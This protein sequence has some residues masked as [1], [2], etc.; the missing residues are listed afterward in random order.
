MKQKAAPP[1]PLRGKRGLP[2]LAAVRIAIALLLLLASC[3]E[4]PAGPAPISGTIETDVVRIA[5]RHGGRIDQILS[6]EGDEVTNN[7]PLFRLAAPELAA[8]REQIAANLAELRAGARP[9]ELAT[10]RAELEAIAAELQ[11]AQAEERRTAQLTETGAIA[12]T[13]RERAVARAATLQK[14]LAAAQARL[15]LL[16]AGARKERIAAAEAQL[17]ELAAHIAELEINSPTNAIL[18]TLHVK[19]GD[20]AGPNTP[21]AT[22]V[23]SDHLWVRIYVPATWLGHLKLNDAVRVRVDSFPDKDFQGQ[24]EQIGRV[25]EFTPRNVQTREDRIKQ[26][27]PIKIRLAAGTE[28]LRAGMS[29]DAYFNIP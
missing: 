28:Q 14:N 3:A 12:A 6:N 26:V 24:I 10:A 1:L 25:A 27:Y 7:Q 15:D 20:V 11:F 16:V 9:E 22:L 5:S 13:D 2:N 18:E 23:L 21:L 29:A 17:A 8:R 4:K 19:R